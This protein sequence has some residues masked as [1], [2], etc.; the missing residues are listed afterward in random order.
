MA[1][2]M[3]AWTVPS[4]WR[5]R[6]AKVEGDAMHMARLVVSGAVLVFALA[7]TGAG[8]AQEDGTR[9][10]DLD[11]RAPAVV[12]GVVSVAGPNQTPT[13]A[14]GVSP[15]LVAAEGYGWT[16]GLETDDPRLSGEFETNQN[17][18]EYENGVATRTGVGRLINDGGSWDVVFRGYSPASNDNHYAMSFTGEDGYEGLSARL[19][20]HPGGPAFEVD[21]VIAPDLWPEPP[22]WVLPPS[23]Q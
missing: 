12:T 2:T 4:H 22:E 23:E 15:M 8:I 10:G 7:P 1:H 13:T 21:G 16:L 5:T 17:V 6:P 3:A 18:Y 11:P 9:E 20:V 19:W 14:H